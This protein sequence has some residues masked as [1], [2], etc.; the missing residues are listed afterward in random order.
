MATLILSSRATPDS[1]RLWRA[2]IARQWDV[3]RSIGPKLPVPLPGGPYLIYHEA[4]FAPLI[5]QQLGLSLIEPP[6]D[7]LARLPAKYTQ[8]WIQFTT[9]SVARS[10]ISPQFV[11]PPN[12][13]SFTAQV[14]SNGLDLPSEP[15]E[16][17]PVLISEPVR[18]MIEF[19]CFIVERRLATISPYLEDGILLDRNEYQTDPVYVN[20]AFKFVEQLLS[21]STVELP[22]A[23][24]LDVG[25]I[26]N[27]DWAVV[28]L[29]PA[30][31]SGIYGCDADAVLDVLIKA[32]E[33]LKESDSEFA[34]DDRSRSL[35][36][37][38]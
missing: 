30:Y 28:E 26:Q 29:N 35:L 19:R 13:K 20:S 38:V 1:Q 36:R 2:A 14:Y 27:R 25:Y 8:R 32:V 16:S 21:D 17:S 23:V 4:L 11:K 33:P 18:W 37:P 24:V 15:N 9:M 6:E 5:A 22:R 34:P 3:E 12:D 10:S 31:S 7:W